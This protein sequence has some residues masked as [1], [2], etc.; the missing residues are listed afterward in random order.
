M[1]IAAPVDAAAQ[2]PEIAGPYAAARRQGSS[3]G[4]SSGARS[5]SGDSPVSTAVEP[6]PQ[7]V[8]DAA[9]TK[10]KTKPLR[11]FNRDRMDSTRYLIALGPEAKMQT[12][13]PDLEDSVIGLNTLLGEMQ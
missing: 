1:E 8:A 7:I 6:K 3:A 10:T 4:S 12:A 13:V 11:K 5:E 2:S 9:K